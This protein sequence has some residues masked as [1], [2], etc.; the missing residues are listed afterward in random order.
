MYLLPF[1]F[2]SITTL[3]CCSQFTFP[4]LQITHVAVLNT[5]FKLT[6]M[7]KLVQIFSQFRVDNHKRNWILC[8]KGICVRVLIETLTQTSINT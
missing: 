5:S 7:S 1:Y 2:L 4:Y 3:H 8:T 6:T